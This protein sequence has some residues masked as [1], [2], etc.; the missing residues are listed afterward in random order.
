MF[1]FILFGSMVW[2]WI[3]FGIWALVLFVSVEMDKPGAAT[4]TSLAFFG[5]FAFWGAL[6]GGGSILAWAAANPF[7]LILLLVAFFVCGTIWAVVKWWFFVRRLAEKRRAQL[8]VGR[9]YNKIRKP[10]VSDNKSRIMTWMCF[11]P[12]SFLWTMIDDPIRMVFKAIYTKIRGLLQ[13]IADK[14]FEGLEDEDDS[15]SV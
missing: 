12:F 3:V 6:P 4:L 2:F 10:S 8:E 9:T 11:W 14:A 15:A 5:V 7:T 13:R 1:E